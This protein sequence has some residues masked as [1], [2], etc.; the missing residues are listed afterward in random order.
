MIKPQ[1]VAGNYIKEVRVDGKTLNG[2]ALSHDALTG[3]KEIT[4]I[5]KPSK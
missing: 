1:D 2:Y 3:A 4:Y 5:L